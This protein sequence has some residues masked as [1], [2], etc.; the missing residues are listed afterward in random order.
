V[1]GWVPAR[2]S[3]RW[4]RVESA[5]TVMR[6]FILPSCP[7]LSLGSDSLHVGNT[8]PVQ[9]HFILKETLS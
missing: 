7:K 4:V 1:T 5:L 2:K 3:S 9:T 6:V 8:P